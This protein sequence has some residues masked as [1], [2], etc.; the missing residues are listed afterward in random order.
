MNSEQLTNLVR[1]DRVHGRVY[2]DPQIFDL[3][4]KRLWRKTWLFGCH[5]SQIPATGD[6]FTT[7]LAKQPIIFTRC[8]DGTIA[9]LY[10][11]CVHRGT[12]LCNQMSGNARILQCPY[13]GWS[14]RCDGTLAGIP[15]KSAYSQEFLGSADLNLARVPNVGQY[16]GF[17]FVRFS[18]EGVPFDEFVTQLRSGIDSLLDRSPTGDIHVAGL[19]RYNYAG[20]WKLQIENGVD[21]YHPFFAHASTVNKEGRQIRRTYGDV[22]GKF[23]ERG[24]EDAATV[25]RSVFD[26]TAKVRRFRYGQSCLTTEDDKERLSDDLLIPEYRKILVERHGE[27]RVREIEDETRILNA[28]FYPNLI[29]RVTGNL[30]IR[31]I[32]PIAVDQTEVWVWPLVYTG[33]SDEM[34]RGIIR[35][36]NMHTSSSS[37]VQSDDLEVFERAHAGMLAE[38]PEWVLL[39]RGLGQETP[40]KLPGEGVAEG[41]WESGMRTQFEHWKNLMGGG[42]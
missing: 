14:Y 37:F 4:M 33:V 1:P 11:R 25:S 20:N 31:V 40:G 17:V 6:F 32:K 42:E 41:T 13:H 29:L 9:A 28:V 18:A 12:L 21:E 24:D 16:R 5:E 35:Y 27:A 26:D 10:N 23:A 36:G 39:A 15:Y 7:T 2:T 34:R 8:A 30:H 22:E 19:H 3:E 38:A